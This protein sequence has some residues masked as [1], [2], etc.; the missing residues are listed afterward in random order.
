MRVVLYNEEDGV[1]LGSALGL[2]FWSKLDPVGQPC[3]VTFADEQEALAYA[4]TW[5]HQMDVRAVPVE[6]YEDVD[7]YW[8]ASIAACQKA[9]LPGWD[10]NAKPARVEGAR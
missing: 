1:Y 10:P 5:D 9:G 2:G 3:A 6:T 7:G 4:K 8:Y